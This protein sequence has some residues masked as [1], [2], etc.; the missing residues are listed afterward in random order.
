MAEGTKAYLQDKDGKNLLV[1]S[2]WSMVQNKPNNLATTNQLPVLS[3]WQRDG[4]V[5]K[6]GAFDWDH[7]NN[8]W[9]CAYRIADMG[10]FKIIEL[11]LV[12]GV[13]H[14]ITTTTEVIDLPAA[15]R[16]DG[17][18]EH[19]ELSSAGWTPNIASVSFRNDHISIAK[20]GTDKVLANTE[21]S[22]HLVY[23]TTL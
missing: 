17:N 22:F 2:D 1:A 5:Y 16:P 11:R 12:F 4:L 19:S 20:A 3:N 15:I 9:N 6:N 8:G 13:D 14:D 21:I 7:V 18:I 23:F 10:S